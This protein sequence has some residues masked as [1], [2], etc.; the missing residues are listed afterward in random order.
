MKHRGIYVRSRPCKIQCCRAETIVTCHTTQQ[1]S[2]LHKSPSPYSLC[3]F[4]EDTYVTA[5]EGTD[6]YELEQTTPRPSTMFEDCDPDNILSTCTSV[7]SVKDVKWRVA[8][9]N[10]TADEP[11]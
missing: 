10:G 2:A 9:D 8:I 4:D 1:A 3:I 6:E 5:D 7:C 11:T